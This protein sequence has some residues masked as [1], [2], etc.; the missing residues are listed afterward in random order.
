MVGRR[1]L[2]W[3]SRAAGIVTAL[4]F[5]LALVR[6][7][8]ALHQQVHQGEQLE[9]LEFHL[10]VEF[11]NAAIADAAFV[12]AVILLVFGLVSILQRWF[13]RPVSPFASRAF[14]SRAV[15][16]AGSA[17]LASWLL[18]N[19][20]ALGAQIFV[21][22]NH[23]D[24]ILIVIDT[25]RRDFVG[26]Y[27]SQR[28]ATPNIDRFAKKSFVFK[29]AYSTSSWTRPAIAS[30]LTSKT[31]IEHGITDEDPSHRLAP[32]FLTL[33]EYFR[34][35]HYRT[36]AILT[37]EQYRLG[38]DQ[39]FETI[40]ERPSGG[41]SISFSEGVYDDAIAFLRPRSF[42]RHFMLIHAID[43]HDAYQY[44]DGF[45]TTPKKSPYRRLEAFLPVRWRDGVTWESEENQHNVIP[46]PQ[47]A[48]D[49][50]KA[51]YA[52][53]VAYADHHLGRFIDYL[54]HSG[55]LERSIVII[56]SDHGEEF[57]DHGSYWHGGTLYEELIQVPLI[58][59]VP[60]LGKGVI[61]QRVSLIDI[62][63]TLID[64]AG[65][66]P[67]DSVLLTGRSLVPLLRGEVLPSE[68]IFTATGMRGAR[69][70]S[71]IVDDLKLIQ[72][73]TGEHIGLFD[74]ARDPEE[75]W[76]LGDDARLADLQAQLARHIAV[77]ADASGRGTPEPLD[78][79]TR[80]ALEALGYL[81][82]SPSE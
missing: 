25:L 16:V 28:G 65:L 31:P 77:A 40:R 9:G 4:G 49:E 22:S 18:V 23:P 15:A 12:F 71:V 2:R 55:W 51:N 7:P 5:L 52:G 59:Y 62:F 38:V 63:P 78:E 68:P 36:H 46:L 20:V 57:L 35:H 14:R 32:G 42:F 72:Y 43:P 26:V 70:F 82:E 64:A 33:Q 24:V 60:E 73:A 44:K 19:C 1:V 29:Q 50:L 34:A 69:K 74:L 30:L 13:R 10:A 3:M 81:D 8:S 53:E 56:T 76:D 75:R 61:D 45:S 79:E 37:N 17:S 11:M 41:G 67:P 6:V 58:I 66:S 21:P 39:N 48:L 47:V 80:K 27:G 54:E